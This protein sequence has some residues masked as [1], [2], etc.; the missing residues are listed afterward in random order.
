MFSIIIISLPINKLMTA[1]ANNIQ[2]LTECCICC[3]YLTD[4]RETP[5]CHQL[6]CQS[7]IQSW[8]ETSTKT[9]PRCRST[10]LTPQVLLHNVVIQRF[11]D[12]LQFDCPNK[13]EGCPAKVPRSDLDTHKNAC[14]YSSTKLAQQRREKLRELNNLRTKYRTSKTR[15]T[16]Q[17]IYDLAKG[18]FAIQEY[19]SARECLQMVKNKNNLPE[20]VMLQ[21]Q[22][23][24]QDNKYDTAL[25]L[26]GQAF[27]LAK[28]VPQRIE[29]LLAK[30]QLYIKKAQ[31]NQAK[32]S[33]QKALDLLPS[34]GPTQA[35]AEILNA[36]GLIAK[37]CSEVRTCLFS[38]HQSA[39]SCFSTIKRSRRTTKLWRLSTCILSSGQ[40]SSPISLVNLETLFSRGYD[41]LI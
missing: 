15:P 25:Q 38:D 24:G 17:A 22:I 7:C 30:G 26:Y 41:P 32:E 5:C 8:L 14:E 10:N 4:V 6:F 34:D 39:D 28:T 29:I 31:Y 2:R 11:V 9:C 20:M 16:D 35:R 33:V 18:F 21:A 37:K 36:R 27:P 13:L 40:K 12:D 1:T 3:D 23:E 19:Q